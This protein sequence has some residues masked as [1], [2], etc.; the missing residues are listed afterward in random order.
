MKLIVI[1]CYSLLYNLNLDYGWVCEVS[2]NA[3][4]LL[5][6]RYIYVLIK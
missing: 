3:M 1:V 5:S 2:K 4:Y 6:S